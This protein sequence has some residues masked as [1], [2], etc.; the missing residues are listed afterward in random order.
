MFLFNKVPC[1]IAIDRGTQIMSFFWK[2]FMASIGIK[3]HNST[4]HHPQTDGQNER[5]NNLLYSTKFNSLMLNNT[6]GHLISLLPNFHITALHI[7]HL[8]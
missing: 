5:A 3:L 8:A 2:K 7:Y 1:I 4:A 6:T